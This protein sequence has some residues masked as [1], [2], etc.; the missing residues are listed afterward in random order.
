MNDQAAS[1]LLVKLL[2]VALLAYGGGF[3]LFVA[4]LPRTPPTPLHGDAIVALT[5]G[6][7]RLD[8]AVALFEHGIGKRL[9][10]T[11][12]YSRTTKAELKKLNH[13]G[14][15]FDCCVDLGCAAADTHGNAV[16]TAHW[17]LAHHYKSLIVVTAGYH[18]P[19]SLTEFSAA[20][21][22]VELVP[23]PVEPAE[24]DLNVWWRP[25]HH[26]PVAR[27]ICPLPRQPCDHGAGKA[28]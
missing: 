27:R 17:A 28:G 24:I 23:Y 3:L 22:N 13:G 25:A 8:A 10:I 4:S 11:G 12:V 15:R 9:L 14:P 1:L 19:R 7:A 6:G 16:E 21:P 2:A 26:A 18:M 5:G 20:M